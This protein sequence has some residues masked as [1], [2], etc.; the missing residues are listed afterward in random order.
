MPAIDT[1]FRQVVGGRYTSSLTSKDFTTHLQDLKD[2]FAKVAELSKSTKVALLNE[3]AA[4]IAAIKTALKNGEPLTSDLAK[5]LT[6]FEKS[7]ATLRAEV[8]DTTKF[9]QTHKQ[10]DAFFKYTPSK[11]NLSPKTD[12][13]VATVQKSVDVFAAKDNAE[14]A[15]KNAVKVFYAVCETEGRLLPTKPNV[16]AFEKAEASVSKKYTEARESLQQYIHAN[17]DDAAAV[18]QFEKLKS[19]Y[20]LFN[21][22]AASVREELDFPRTS[23]SAPLPKP[24]KTIPDGFPQPKALHKQYKTA[25]EAGRVSFGHGPEL[26]VSQMIQ[27]ALSELPSNLQTKP[28]VKIAQFISLRI[29]ETHQLT[30]DERAALKQQLSQWVQFAGGQ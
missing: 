22:K 21:L 19:D 6:Q 17:P 2:A 30:T 23:Y 9:T 3:T 10:P 28:P 15:V 5:T 20:N 1:F 25:P 13:F 18:L 11:V 16:D 4:A 12:D 8:D 27:Q 29:D 7:A 26:Q 14:A 24:T